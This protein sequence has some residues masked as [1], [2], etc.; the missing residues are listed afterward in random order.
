MDRWTLDPWD[1]GI[2]ETTLN[3]VSAPFYKRRLVFFL[4]EEIWDVLEIIDDPFEFMTD[5]RKVKHIEMLLSD[6][7]FERAAKSIQ[8]EVAE[9]PELKITVLNVD[10]VIG[11]H[12]SWFEKDE[13]MTWDEVASTI[14]D[15][16]DEGH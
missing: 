7:L 1:R 2:I 6:E 9:S 4:L 15:A 5:A 13:S 14:K 11:Q 10:E 3:Q 12:P 16:L 8:L